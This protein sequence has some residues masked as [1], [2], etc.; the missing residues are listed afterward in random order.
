VIEQLSNF[1]FSFNLRR[2]N[3]ADNNLAHFFDAAAACVAVQDDE[4]DED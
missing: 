4:S 2:Y 3:L 1:A